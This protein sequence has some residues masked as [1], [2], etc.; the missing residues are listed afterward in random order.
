MV[1]VHSFHVAT[2]WIGNS[3]RVAQKHSLQVTDA[4]FDRAIRGGA[5]S[6]AVVQNPVQTVLDG[7]RHELPL[8]E[9]NGLE[10]D[11]ITPALSTTDGR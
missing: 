9:R 5:E 10:R 4:D 1:A 2:N 3:A 11:E 8:S 6:G 7:T